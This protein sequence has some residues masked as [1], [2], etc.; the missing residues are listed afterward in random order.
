MLTVNKTVNSLN[1]HKMNTQFPYDDSV[2][3]VQP[4]LP[5]TEKPTKN[6]SGGK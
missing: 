5:D 3:H 1:S 6:E 4:P 2:D